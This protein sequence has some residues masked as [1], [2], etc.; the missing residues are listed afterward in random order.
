M[1]LLKCSWSFT[2][3]GWYLTACMCICCVHIVWMFAMQVF[4]TL[5]ATNFPRQQLQS[6]ER[7]IWKDTWAFEQ[8]VITI[9]PLWWVSATKSIIAIRGLPIASNFMNEATNAEGHDNSLLWL[10]SPFSLKRE[11]ARFLSN[12]GT[13]VSFPWVIL[14]FGW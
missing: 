6:L 1:N 5:V 11:Q 7:D 13:R 8:T 10:L 2:K 4:P 14:H 9:T 12:T 3:G